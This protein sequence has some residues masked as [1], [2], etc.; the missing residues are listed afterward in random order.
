MNDRDDAM[1][2]VPAVT[3][4]FWIIKVL[5]TTLGETGGDTVTMTWLGETTSH[6][7]PNGYLIGTAIFGLLLMLLVWAQ[8]KSRKF[9]PWLYWATIVASTTC[10]T[11]LADFATRSLGI[12][13][14]GGSLLLLA[15]VLASLFAWYR[16]LGT[17]DVNTVSGSKV[18]GFYWVTITFSQTLGTALGDW[19]ADAGLGYGGGAL[20]FGAALAVL[21]ILYFTTKFSHVFMFWAAFILTRPLGAT[22][23]DFLDKPV[24]KGGLEMSRPIA[25]AVLAMVILAYSFPAATGGTTSRPGRIPRMTF[26]RAFTGYA[27]VCAAGPAFAGPP[28]LTDDPVPTDAGH[29]EI[30]GFAAGDGRRSALDTDVGVDLNYGPVE[31]VQLTATLPLSFSHTPAEGWRGGAGDVEIGVKYRFFHD[32]NNG[33]SAAIFPRTIFPTASYSAGEKARFLLPLWLGKDFDGGTSLFGGG[34]YTINP[35]AENRDF[36]QAA[37]AITHE[38]SSKFSAGAE[39]AHQ[40]TDTVGGSAQTRAGVGSIVRLSSHYA[41]LVSAG[42]SWADHQTGYHF[43]GALGLN[44]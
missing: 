16:T 3:L 38:L 32:E 39:I 44:F 43:Y 19:V 42:P 10:G 35:G 17:V 40:G 2:K 15:C 11:T 21:A 1:T 8:I 5:A 36:W 12:G 27:L 24:N 25:S 9:N 41:L 30:Y 34:G 13:Y 33:L 4:G 31:G 22:V 28:Y 20:L 29:W 23:G 37:V 6:P 7:V 18:E 14:P 26:L